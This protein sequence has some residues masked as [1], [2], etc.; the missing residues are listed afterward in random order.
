MPLTFQPSSSEQYGALPSWVPFLGKPGAGFYHYKGTVYSW[1]PDKGTI[2]VLWEDNSPQ[3]KLLPVGSEAYDRG[4][5][6][7][8]IYREPNYTEGELA[9]LQSLL[10]ASQVA[11][12]AQPSATGPSPDDPAGYDPSDP[13]YKQTWFIPAVVGG[14][15]LSVGTYLIITRG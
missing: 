12:M 5:A 14:I 4:I 11:Q 15:I 10:Q 8:K 1:D 3:Q 9:V 7:T 13:F 6:V 2:K